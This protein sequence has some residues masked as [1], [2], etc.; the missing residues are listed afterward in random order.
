MSATLDDRPTTVT[1]P[2]AADKRRRPARRRFVA[3]VRTPF[4][5]IVPAVLLYALVT[6]LPNISGIVLSFTDWNGAS[7]VPAFV[8]LENYQS[9]LADDNSVRA[10]INTFVITIVATLAQNVIGLLLALGLNTQVKSKYVL[11]LVFFLPVVLTPIVAG[12]LWKYLLTPQ[13][14]LNTM[15]GDL[16]LDSLQQ[17]WLGNP[18]LV[19]YA[20]CA[21]IVWQGAGYS[22]VIYLAGLQAVSADTLEAAAIDGAGP[23]R[24]T[25]S[26]T[27][28]LI[29]GSIV[30]NLLLCVLGNLKQFDTVFSMTG[31]GPSGASET[32]ATIV[33]KTAFLYL[34]Y[35]NALAQ[36]VILTILVGVIGFV[37]FRITQRKALS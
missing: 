28:P 4:W 30:V 9:V 19:L 2:P 12:Y 13:G 25:W 24:R 8:G 6:L 27:I 32:M 34:Q 10:I 22:M 16:G 26:I 18:N 7:G 5:F 29:N 33:Y 36:G 35:P 1:P 17:D 14:T 11:R 20:V 37:Q 21:T 23:F 3:G 15:L 31:G